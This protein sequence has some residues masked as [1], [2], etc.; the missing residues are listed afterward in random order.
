MQVK[1][2]KTP[3]E[4]LKEV[5]DPIIRSAI[6]PLSDKVAELKKNREILRELLPRPSSNVRKVINSIDDVIE[7]LMHY[8]K[9]L[10]KA[11]CE[12]PGNEIY[13]QFYTDPSEALEVDEYLFIEEIDSLHTR[14]NAYLKLDLYK[15]LPYFQKLVD[16]SSILHSARNAMEKGYIDRRYDGGY[17]ERVGE[18]TLLETDSHIT[19]LLEI[20]INYKAE[21][22]EGKQD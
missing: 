22:H 18:V 15:P 19:T 21:E 6:D 9:M 13:H 7:I 10:N 11:Y 8:K 12:I 1:E 2:Y 4:A 3:E 14:V 16:Y 20:A 5:K 17:V